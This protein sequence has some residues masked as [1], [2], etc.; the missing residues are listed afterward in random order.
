MKS[1]R[2][3][4]GWYGWIRPLAWVAGIGGVGLA[5]MLAFGAAAQGT[6]QP[7]EQAPVALKSDAAEATHSKNLPGPADLARAFS[8]VVKQVG[9]AVVNIST[10]Q[11]IRARSGR[12]GGPFEDFFERFFGAPPPGRQR[13]Q[14]LGSG[15][16]VDRRGY[17]LTNNHVV[18]EADEITVTLA[19]ESEHDAKIV[20]TDPATDLAVIQIEGG[21][22]FPFLGL[23]D[24]EKLEVGE[25]VLAVGNPFGLE[26]TVTA[27]IISAKG[28]NISAGVYDDFLQTDAAINPGNSGGPLVNMDGEVVGINSNIVSSGPAGGNLGIGFAIPSN[29]ARKV[30]GQLVEHGSV[31]RGWLGVSIQN[32]TPDLARSF[33]L[34]GQKGALIG[35]LVGED[36]PARKAG[37]EP[38]DIVIEFNGRKVESDH[39]LVQMVA[40]V[41]PGDTVELKFY[42]DGKVRTASV[43]VGKRE[44]DLV[45]DSSGAERR[46]DRGR[47][48]VVAQD[49]TPQLASQLGST[50]RRGVVIMQVEPDGPAASAGLLQGD[51]IHQ[52]N[53]EPIEGLA[54]LQ[55]VL[56]RV[57]EGG[58]LLLRVER[59]TG[60]QPAFL[61]LHV[62][63]D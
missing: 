19:D 63:L 61:F 50:S 10:E 59:T 2:D 44:I 54:D 52:A 22:G 45:S 42:R 12:P 53:R 21:E 33:G 38:G 51:I 8:Q 7:E 23:G 3:G 27:G 49:L 46:D 16:I 11:V 35:D 39:H 48:G 9:P 57:P 5:L 41:P 62:E 28:R 6:L 30:Y 15:V 25:W 18:A 1:D 58:D 20:G 26:H 55:R 43:K 31:A 14:S 17:V 34:E 47:L 37:L 13:R 4:A 56:A 36:S 32:L 29:L 60:N 24:S 40:D